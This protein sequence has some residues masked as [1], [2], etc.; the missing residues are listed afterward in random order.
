MKAAGEGHA[1]R[2]GRRG[3]NPAGPGPA[4]GGY[5]LRRELPLASIVLMVVFVV[6]GSLG[7]LV[8]W[9]AGPANLDWGVWLLVYG[10]YVYL[11]VAALYHVRTGR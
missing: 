10:G 1:D 7:I 5:T 9:P 2:G 4:G 11:I 8:E 6:V 3:G